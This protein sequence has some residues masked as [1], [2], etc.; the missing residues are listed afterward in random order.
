[1]PLLPQPNCQRTTGFRAQKT[2]PETRRQFD[3]GRLPAA[4]QAAMAGNR[5]LSNSTTPT[6]RRNGRNTEYTNRVSGCQRAKRQSGK[7]SP[8]CSKTPLQLGAPLR[9]TRQIAGDYPFAHKRIISD[10]GRLTTHP[11]PNVTTSRRW[12]G[13][14]FPEL[15]R[16]PTFNMYPGCRSY[17]PI[18]PRWGIVVV[19]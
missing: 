10:I 16:S 5:P 7:I 3:G 17:W 13:D 12:P 1:M 2:T 14:V 6:A 9:P 19:R 11:N 18:S 8:P 4:P 15:L